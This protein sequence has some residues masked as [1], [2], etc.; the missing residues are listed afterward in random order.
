MYAT[1]INWDKSRVQQVSNNRSNSQELINK[2]VK[3][4]KRRIKTLNK[5]MY[6]I[7]SNSII[8]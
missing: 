3:S 5:F 4:Y 8:V 2:K 7:S 6:L 1:G